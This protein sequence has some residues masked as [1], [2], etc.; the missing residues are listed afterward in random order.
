MWPNSSHHIPYMVI[1]Y[2][3]TEG[4]LSPIDPHPPVRWSQDMVVLGNLQEPKWQSQSEKR[5]PLRG[6][7]VDGSEI[8]R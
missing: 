5:T 3:F 1:L 7:I 4:Q 8:R 6:D 2:L